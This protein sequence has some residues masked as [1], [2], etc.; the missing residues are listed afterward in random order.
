M[1]VS[2]A[3]QKAVD[4][5]VRANYDRIEFKAP[6]GQKAEIQAHAQARGESVNSF[7]IRAIS[8]AMECDQATPADIPQAPPQAVEQPTDGTLVLVQRGTVAGSRELKQ[9]YEALKT[10]RE[11]FVEPVITDEEWAELQRAKSIDT[12]SD[13]LPF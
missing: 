5:Y 7:I 2:K 4:K 13:D 12:D 6:K 11:Y 9:L 1:P 10:G 8:M 3:Q